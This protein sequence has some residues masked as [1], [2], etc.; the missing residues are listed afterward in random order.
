MKPPSEELE[1]RRPVWEALSA[2]FLDNE[3]DEAAR[4]RIADVL[5]LSGYTLPELESILWSELCPVLHTN[6]LG[7]AGEWSGFDVRHVEQRILAREAGR[8]RQWWSYLNGGHIARH[9]W[10]RIKQ[11]MVVRRNREIGLSIRP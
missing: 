4:A 2:I 7:T 1:R 11:A 9:E 3:I 10:R 6:L 5:H 8:L